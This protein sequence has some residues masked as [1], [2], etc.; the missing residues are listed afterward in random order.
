MAFISNDQLF[1]MSF[2]QYEEFINESYVVTNTPE[3][4][5]IRRVGYRLADAAQKLLISEG[6]PNYLDDYQWEFTLVFD[7]SINAW[8]MPGGKI[9]FYTGILPVTLNEAGIAVVMGHEIAHAILNHGQQRMSAGILQQIGA[10][11]VTIATANQSPAAQNLIM[12]AYGVGSNVGAAL[13][14]SRQHEHEADRYGLLL[15]AIAGYN[16]DEAADFWER[17]SSIGGGGIPEFLSTHPSPPNRVRNLQE[18]APEAKS[19]AAGF[20]VFF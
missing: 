15:M 9:V 3:A 11:G 14:F 20:G 16:P 10:L 8:A 17:M 6:R 7:E 13:P 4:E 2:S 18:Y 5:M 12:L 19:R 1:E